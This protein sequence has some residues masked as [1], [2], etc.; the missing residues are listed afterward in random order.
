MATFVMFSILFLFFHRIITI[1]FKYHINCT[2]LYC[3]YF[4][5]TLN[6]R[7]S[8]GG[9]LGASSLLKLFNVSLGELRDTEHARACT[10]THAHIRTQ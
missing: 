10:Q 3:F 6:Q 7:I 1:C 9:I 4:F 8:L 5:F 2:V